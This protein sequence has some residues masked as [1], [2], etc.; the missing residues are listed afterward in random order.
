MTLV[1]LLWLV[2][3]ALSHRSAVRRAAESATAAAAE[4]AKAEK[5]QP[6]EVAQ[7]PLSVEPQPALAPAT[8]NG[9]AQIR[10]RINQEAER[11]PEAAADLLRR[12]M[13]QSNGKAAE[14]HSNG[15]PAA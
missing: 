11:D 12:W 14:T 1:C 8:S 9:F 10:V 3:R 4:S 13:K 15:G 2:K 7:A 6:S 5:Q